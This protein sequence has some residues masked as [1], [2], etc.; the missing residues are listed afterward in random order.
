M[1]PSVGR[2]AVI[3]LGIDPG[4]KGALAFLRLQDASISDLEDMPCIGK[5]VN[6]HMLTRLIQGYGPVHTAVVEQAHS[7]PKQGVAGVFTYGV[8]YG[9]ILGVLAAL[10]IPIVHMPAGHWKTKMH[11]NQDKALS[12]QRAT[13]RWPEW[14]ESFKMVK[15]DGRA[16]ACLMTA[17]WISENRVPRTKK[18]TLIGAD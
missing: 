11:L 17:Y 13:E 12:R 3:I 10:D 4:Q 1:S 14:S 5:E 6:A 9:K 2:N 8:G 16:E 18:P 15:H 7:M